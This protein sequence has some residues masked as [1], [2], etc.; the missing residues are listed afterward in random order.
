M[1][2]KIKNTLAG[3]LCLSAIS[4]P[5]HAQSDNS[6]GNGFN[7][8]I[9]LILQG[10]YADLESEAEA[11]IPGFLLGPETEFRNDGF[12]LGETEL[13]FEATVD[14]LFRGWATIALEDE[15]G[16]TETV[17]EEAY[18]ETLSLPQGLGI[19]FG[20]FFSDIGYLNRHHSHTWEFADAPLVY[21]AM[22]ANKLRD[23]GIQLRWVAPT[24]FYLE[25]G[26]E[27]LRGIG[28][29][30]TG[31]SQDGVNTWTFFARTGGDIGSG[32]SWRLGYSRIESDAEDREVEEEDTPIHS[33]TG[34]S[35][36]NIIDVV[37]KWAPNR[38][39]RERN[40]VLHF[41]YFDREE[42]GEVTDLQT[43]D[44]SPYSGAQTG[45][46]LEGVY[47]FMPRWR[48]GLRYGQ[49]E[50]DNQVTNPVADTLLEELA[51]D[52]GQPER[53][54]AMMDYSHS[55]FSRFRLQFN[56]DESRVNGEADNQLILQYIHSIGA[57]PAHSY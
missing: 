5:A 44:S 31:E 2:F 55:E 26:G 51:R 6:F 11:E 38:N 43:A 54:S 40:F 8:K 19:K 36:L 13:S 27:A 21:R 34:D 14:D 3:A 32:G 7:P 46:Y 24:D 22:L 10:S 45:F 50:A 1:T 29:P 18:L 30:A 25:L 9:S 52:S 41:E 48:A 37:Y 12:S 39:P 20:R 4:L 28:F 57:H 42:S 16:E 47:Q 49:L 17:V 23:D 53:I 56:K 33:F 35:Q 15:G